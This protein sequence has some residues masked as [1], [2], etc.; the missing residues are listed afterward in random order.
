MCLSIL[1]QWRSI[2][3]PLWSG[4][5][6]GSFAI[7]RVL[8]SVVFGLISIVKEYF[9]AGSKKWCYYCRPQHSIARYKA[10]DRTAGAN[11]LQESSL[12]CSGKD[13]INTQSCVRSLCLCPLRTGVDLLATRRS[14]SVDSRDRSPDDCRSPFK[15]TQEPAPVYRIGKD[16]V[17]SVF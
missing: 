1:L 11:P 15:P 6:D 12:H 5:R 16:C 8:R 10:N 9:L 4:R 13:C 14:I 2:R 17:Y 7:V 3:S